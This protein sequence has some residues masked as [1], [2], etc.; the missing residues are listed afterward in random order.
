MTV[1]FRLRHSS[2]SVPGNGNG[3][4]LLDPRILAI[5]IVG[6]VGRMLGIDTSLQGFILLSHLLMVAQIG[7]EGH[8]AL[9]VR[10]I[11]LIYMNVMRA[12]ILLVFGEITPPKKAPFTP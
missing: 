12:I 9:H 2:L 3:F 6:D 5:I 10:V 1:S 8:V 7:A 4:E 11:Y